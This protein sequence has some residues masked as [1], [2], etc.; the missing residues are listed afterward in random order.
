MKTN[1]ATQQSIYLTRSKYAAYE[2]Q[3]D[4]ME[5][6]GSRKLSRLLASAPGSGMG[7]PM[8]LPIH[9]LARLFYSE[10][11]ELRFKITHAVFIE[12]TVASYSDTSICGIGATI[13]ITE[14]SSMETDVYT[15]L[16]S[17]E[18]NPSLGIISHLS[19]IG[20]SVMG[21]KVGDVIDLK[22][23][24]LKF[25][26]DKVEYRSLEIKNEPKDWDTILNNTIV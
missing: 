8:D 11:D 16:G 5:K 13:T 17:D 23:N 2:Q 26:I 7:R 1:L 25:R 20:A 18:A 10:I 22:T 24:G 6:E 14:L 12:D 4:Y 21:K 3:L 19:P 15:I 9:D